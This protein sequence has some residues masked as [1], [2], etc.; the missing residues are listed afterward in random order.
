M[1]PEKLYIGIDPGIH[2]GLAC[3]NS[4]MEIISAVK[5]PKTDKEVWAWLDDLPF[6]CYKV[7]TIEEIT[8]RPTFFKGKSSILR[9]TCILYGSY[10]FLSGMLAAADIPF[11]TLVPQAW[12]KKLGHVKGH[13]L[14]RKEEKD[15]SWKN[16]L[17]D[18][19]QDRFPQAKVTL[20]TADALLLAYLCCL[21]WRA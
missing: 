2:G 19:A 9:S 14:K 15:S 4:K 17:K 12:Q 6:E 7:A 18:L 5:M 11:N 16:M 21:K 1:T 20:S 8:P 13:R 10:R 3:I